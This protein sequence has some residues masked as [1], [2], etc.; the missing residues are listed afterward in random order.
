[1]AGRPRKKVVKPKEIVVE[2]KVPIVHLSN[3]VKKKEGIVNPLRLNNH[4]ILSN[5]KP[6]PIPGNLLN[7]EM[8]MLH[9]EYLISIDKLERV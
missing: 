3:I 8:F 4:I 1:M 7:D 6:F 9:I 5:Y 2:Q